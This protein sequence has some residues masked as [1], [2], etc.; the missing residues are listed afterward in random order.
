MRLKKGETVTVPVEVDIAS[1]ALTV[2][3]LPYEDIVRFVE[4]VDADVADSHFTVLLH[5]RIVEIRMEK[6]L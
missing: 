5:Q 6:E 2:S 4:Y 1:L 3:E